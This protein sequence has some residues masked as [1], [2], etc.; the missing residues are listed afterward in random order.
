MDYLKDKQYYI[1]FYDLLTIKECLRT[2]EF[3]QEIYKTKDTDKKLKGIPPKEI[4]KGFNYIYTWD[5]R[6]RKG[7]R[8]RRKAET[9]AEWIER[10]RVRQDK[11]DNTSPP[12][13]ILCPS[14]KTEMVAGDFKHLEDNE[15]K[16]LKVIFIFECPKCKKRTWIDE[17][18][19]EDHISK[20]KLCPKCNKEIKTTYKKK[21]EVLTTTEKCTSCKY[22]KIDIDDWG[23]DKLEAEAKEKADKDLLEKY[24]KEFCL[25]DEQGK[26]YIELM[27]SLEVAKVV[28]DEEV[29][30]Y[31]NPTYEASIKIKKTNITDLE[32]L[33]TTV[34]E[35]S[36]YTKLSF[37]KPEIG[38]F[39]IVPFTVQDN[40]SS[41]RDKISV[42][43]LEKLIKTTLEDTNWRLL[44][45]SVSYRL[46]YLEGRLKGYERE[47]DILKLV[48]K[49]NGPDKKPKPKIDEEK[50][51]KYQFSNVVEL[52][53]LSG[54]FKGVENMRKKRLIK[55][56]DGFWLEADKGPYTCGICGENYYGNEIWWDLNGIRCADCRRNVLEGVIPLFKHHRYEDEAEWFES[57]Q[58]TSHHGVH[59][60]TVRKLRRE[61]LLTGRDLKRKDGTIYHT[62]YLVSENQEFLK[63]YPKQEPKLQ[64]EVVDN[65]GNKVNL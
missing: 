54:E 1:D 38:Q 53:K 40:D 27:E 25:S 35:E 18:G 62:V 43:E 44:S 34:F 49:K 4:D 33:L 47:E 41:R 3:W 32:K 31:N 56:P 8:Y 5:L 20:P 6:T 12:L 30:K 64:A 21:D 46:G 28:Y 39:V 55:E 52:A 2:I 26:E 19:K 16:P 61:G 24:R 23:K 11:I 65:K 29:Q 22:K 42:S 57:W 59:P 45:D 58:I 13:D 15:G 51:R 14:C 60:S 7:E 50:M 48:E 63:K 9:I 10:D 36:K 17:N 37:E